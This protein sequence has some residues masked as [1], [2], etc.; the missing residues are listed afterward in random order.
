MS[1]FSLSLLPSKN[2]SIKTP[3]KELEFS[4]MYLDSDGSKI[5]KFGLFHRTLFKQNSYPNPK[6]I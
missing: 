3:H 4:F 2:Q 6:K 5:I 1:L